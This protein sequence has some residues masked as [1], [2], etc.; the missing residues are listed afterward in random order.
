MEFAK[1]KIKTAQPKPPKNSE[2]E[3]PVVVAPD[4]PVAVTEEKDNS[5]GCATCGQNTETAPDGQILVPRRFIVMTI[6]SEM[7]EYSDVRRT[8]M[9]SDWIAHDSTY[10]Q[11]TR[12]SIFSFPTQQQ[13]SSAIPEQMSAM[14][15]ILKDIGK[16]PQFSM[17]TIKVPEPAQEPKINSGDDAE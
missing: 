14:S 6:P 10:D 7:F 17:R 2:P 1:R 5:G 3:T 4:E 13:D 15:K 9:S 11:V 12:K 8:V 16:T